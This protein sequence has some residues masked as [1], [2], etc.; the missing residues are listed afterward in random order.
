MTSYY[1]KKKLAGDRLQQCYEIAPPRVQQY[2]ESE[3]Q[4]LLGSVQA[5]DHVLELGCG[6]GRV[7]LRIADVAERVAGIDVA[8]ESL[9]L[10]RQL[11]RSRRNCE[12]LS[13]DARDLR[14]ADASFD[15][16]ACIQNGVCAFGIDQETMLRE[17][18]RVLR[19]NGVILLSTYADPF[20]PERLAWFELQ[21]EHDLIGPLDRKACRDNTIVCTDGFRSGHV[22]WEQFSSFGKMLGVQAA[23]AEVDGSSLWCELRKA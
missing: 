22:T 21:A 2:L 6:Y 12:F 4:H 9:S 17:A 11:A 8:E 10:A 15:V 5:M 18:W 20:W 1:V 19:P 13:M 7:S 3:I 16:V 23:I 14:F